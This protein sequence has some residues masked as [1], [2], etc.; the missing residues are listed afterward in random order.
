[1]KGSETHLKYVKSLKLK[2]VRICIKQ[3]LCRVAFEQVM[4]NRIEQRGPMKCRQKRVRKEPARL[5]QLIEITKQT[6]KSK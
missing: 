3:K 5:L 6:C 2:N 1:M 4:R